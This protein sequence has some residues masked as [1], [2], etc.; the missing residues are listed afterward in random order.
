MKS[1]GSCNS[2]SLLTLEILTISR[3]L[4]QK[5]YLVKLKRFVQSRTYVDFIAELF[6]WQN[7]TCIIKAPL[8]QVV[9]VKAL[10]DV[11]FQAHCLP[12]ERMI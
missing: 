4:C 8:K 6:L 10:L 2:C 3:I 5:E 11:L 9:L 7:S 1:D 12:G